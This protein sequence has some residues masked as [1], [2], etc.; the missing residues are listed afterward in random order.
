MTALRITPLSTHAALRMM[1]GM[2]TMVLPLV[3]GLGAAAG[4][5]GLVAG[6]VMTGLALHAVADERGLPALP[7]GTLHATDWGMVVGLAGAALVLALAHDPA[8]ALDLR[9]HRP[10]GR[11]RQPHHALQRARLTRA[12]PHRSQRWTT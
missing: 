4:V 9:R 2:A 5:I 6:A 1:T 11:D 12:S 8:A 10:G 3:L 7:V